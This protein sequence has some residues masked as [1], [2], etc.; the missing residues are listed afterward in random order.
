MRKAIS[1]ILIV[2]LTLVSTVIL[3]G[4]ANT[5]VNSP[6]DVIK[7]AYGD[8][9]FRI[10]F[11]STDLEA[12][13][14]DLYYTASNMPI[15]PTPVKV[16]YVFAGWYFDKSL[17]EPCEVDK[18]D[19][20][21]KMK[22]VTL[23]PKW[24]QEKIFNNGTYDIEFEAKIVENSIVKGVFAEGYQEFPN[25]IVASETYIEKN[26]V[27]T[28]LRIQYDNVV[29][30]PVLGS[31]GSDENNFSKMTY[32]VTDP[33]N[34]INKDI[35]I[36]DRTNSIQ[37][38]YLD[39]SN[40]N[41]ADTIHLNIEYYNWKINISDENRKLAS[42]RYEVEFRITRFIGFG[43][44]FINPERKLED[45]MYVLPSHYTDLKK[46]FIMLDA[47]NPVYTYLE[48]KNGNY[49]L[50]K[51]LN[52]YNN[53]FPE[54]TPEQYPLRTSGYARE[55]A[56]MFIDRDKK[57]PIDVEQNLEG[58]YFLPE[59]IGAKG[60]ESITYEFNAKTGKYFYTIN[61]GNTLDK[62]IVFIGGSAGAM[63]QMFNMPFD[64][65]RLRLDYDSM[66]QVID[67]DYKPL[68]G[69]EFTYKD[70]VA[71][72][73]GSILDFK[74][75][76][77]VYDMCMKFRFAIDMTNVFFLQTKN[78]KVDKVFDTKMTIN[79]GKLYVD[80]LADTRFKYQK[81]SVSLSAF[82]YD[83]KVDG[84]L[85]ARDLSFVTN[86][87]YR[88]SNS[89]V[90]A[91]YAGKTFNVGDAV[92][93]KNL[94][95][96]K[97]STSVPSSL[98][99]KVYDVK[100]GLIVDY[101][102]GRNAKN[103]FTFDKNIAIEF[104]SNE[105]GHEKHSLIYVMEK[106]EPKLRII[107]DDWT[108]DKDGIYVTKKRF[109][110]DS[111][112]LIPEVVYNYY[113]ISFSTKDLKKYDEDAYYDTNYT[114]VSAW[115]YTDG[116]YKPINISGREVESQYDF[117]MDSDRIRVL[118]QL[119]NPFGEF[120]PIVLEFRGIDS[121]N[122]TIKLNDK[123]IASGDL[124]FKGT[125]RN[126]I[127]FKMKETYHIGDEIDLNSISTKFDFSYTTDRGT[128]YSP[129]N[130]NHVII[131]LRDK[132][133]TVNSLAEIWNYI[134][135]E[136]Y[137][138]IN[139]VYSNEYGDTVQYK[140]EYN[141]K[142][143]NKPLNEYKVMNT[144]TTIFNGVSFT[145]KNPV[146]SSNSHIILGDGD[147][148]VYRKYG[149]S[150][151]LCEKDDATWHSSSYYGEIT[152]NTS[153]EYLICWEIR[154]YHD[155]N[156]H[157][158]FD[159]VAQTELIQSVTFNFC[160]AVEVIDNKSDMVLTFAT[161][162]K[163]PFNQ[164][165]LNELIVQGYEFNEDSMYQYVTIPVKRDEEIWSLTSDYFKTLDGQ[166]P[167]GHTLFGWGNKDGVRSYGTDSSVKDAMVRQHTLTPILYSIW[168]IPIEID[169]TYDIGGEL[170]KPFDGII[171][172]YRDDSK[173]IYKSR[174][175]QLHI[176]KF[177]DENRELMRDY[178]IYGF[179]ASMPVFE[180]WEEVDGQ[181]TMVVSDF[182]KGNFDV[183]L[184]TKQSISVTAI[185]KKSV[186]VG[187][188]AFS[189]AGEKLKF[190]EEIRKDYDLFSS[191][192]FNQSVD[193]KKMNQLKN[194]LVTNIDLRFKH[195]QAFDKVE[196]KWVIIDLDTL[197]LEERFIDSNGKI[198][199]RAIFG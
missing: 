82:D 43:Q 7:D 94:Y 14:I 187:Y 98:T 99:A 66:V 153:G 162:K 28:F 196:Q 186:Y 52:T 71:F 168:D 151:L 167:L 59:E 69:K 54:I 148:R 104:T 65:R 106:E 8:S 197:V 146:I 190:S 5:K 50:H 3:V 114:K 67:C 34:R 172:V 9:K 159:S 26:A 131:Y 101:S 55:F 56:C 181:Q 134:K 44:S 123:L 170:Y 93:L 156:G 22:N 157:W 180:R 16:G 179:K 164:D 185:F 129:I 105:E 29:R 21:W 83:P 24:E 20:L 53:D 188:E 19:L 136:D 25:D 61:L 103:T 89:S 64:Y 150:Y 108:Q 139:L 12:P 155:E 57:L 195:W 15:L 147:L 96:E 184:T 127:N 62:D 77:T 132:T 183:I 111:T 72:Y 182:Y 165:K 166:N 125:V 87:Q 4:C 126:P 13:L 36:Q 194:P 46:D 119:T 142:I 11:D 149:D 173:V 112:V 73:P 10:S 141:F 199:L 79:P 2:L 70:E 175:Q 144:N 102:T 17:T 133:I 109:S 45:G 158:V 48:V 174:K 116:I 63:E 88:T 38:I 86:L 145:L 120:K 39:I 85:Y 154:L 1:K 58:K 31:A 178:K 115:N 78:G 113:G 92:N 143:N 32:T 110:L 118:M 138:L 177:F 84:K 81:F 27:G 122:Y 117:I 41:L 169:L 140:A 121:G 189:E 160:Q 100:D 37:T 107:G 30:G 135:N 91:K 176:F 124:S 137:A 75:D 47:F 6:E 161:D 40:M 33:K 191:D 18:G 163:H 97:V 76:N 171:K 128:V 130:F 35:S 51:P 198:T 80:S 74:D 42:V 49:I 152:F 95:I 192:E 90:N 68:E 193:F 60:F 23:Y